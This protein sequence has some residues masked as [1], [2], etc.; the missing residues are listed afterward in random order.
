[1]DTRAPVILLIT[2]NPALDS[3][4]SALRAHGLRTVCASTEAEAQQLLDAHRGR[5]VAVLDSFQP[6]PYAFD[7]MYRL[8]HQPP[9][10]P[11]LIVLAEERQHP[12]VRGGKG[13]GASEFAR[14][15]APIPELVLRIQA[16]AMH[17]GLPLP[18]P[19]ER[20]PEGQVIAVFGLKGGIGRS[21]IAANL[22]VGLAQRYAHRVVLV[23]ADPWYGAQRALLDL[24]SEKSLASLRDMAGPLDPEVVG[25]V[26]I[27]HVSGVQVLLG[28]P[29]PTLAETIPADLPTR[30]AAA[31]RAQYDFVVVDTHPSMDET[32]LQVLETA[33]QILLVTTPEMGPL[34]SVMQVLKLAPVLGWEHK[35][36][37]VVN[38]AESGVGVA[39]LEAALGK[40][41]DATLVSAGRRMLEATNRG[42]PVLLA[43]PTCKARISQD[44][45]RLVAQVTGER[46]PRFET[47]AVTAW[48]SPTRFWPRGRATEARQLA[49]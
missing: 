8:L 49:G 19:G 4:G 38:R 29:D 5:C 22:A 41:A 42:Q 27:P 1:M 16:L 32:V 15:P 39:E 10:V 6:A 34:R 45:V 33:D 37:L 31:C 48:W 13:P 7:V 44:L 18:G 30:V 11:S 25:T 46:P 47:P 17:A 3:L 23:D 24:D 43:D 2:A 40:R 26:L 9:A 36:R 14:L 12:A 35:L 21:T 28:L 20:H